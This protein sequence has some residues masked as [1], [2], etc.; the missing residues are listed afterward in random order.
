MQFQV[1]IP[2]NIFI[3]EN[4]IETLPIQIKS[5]YKNLLIISSVDLKDQVDN[6]I[7]ILS[8]LS[9]DIDLFLMD[10]TEPT[11]DQIDSKAIVYRKNNYDLII[12]IGGGSA[13][14]M[15][16]ALAIAL[17]NPEP[18]WNYA[19]LSNRPPSKLKDAP[20]PVIALPTT[21]GTG[22]EVTPYA[23]LTKTET[24]QKGTIQEREIFPMFAIIE[25]S[26][27]MTMPAELTAYTGMDAFAHAFESYINISKIS[28]VAELVATHAIE[29][30]F[31]N[32]KNACDNPTNIDAR[33]NMAWA[34]TLAGIAIS[35]RGTTTPHAIAEPLGTLTKLPHAITVCLCTVPVLKHSYEVLR[36]K[37]K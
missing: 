10:A 9:C 19:N 15:A 20:L 7:N 6:T 14:D 27:L 28:P 1:N 33:L 26:F 32:L 4:V 22:S 34:S 16:K 36:E 25:P 8:E 21:S 29:L 17:K 30:I 2:T 12:G 37:L 35:H 23:V 31:K 18:I 3:G 13:I 5:L 24:Q 11:T